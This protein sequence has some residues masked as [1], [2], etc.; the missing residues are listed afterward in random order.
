MAAKSDAVILCRKDWSV[1]RHVAATTA[2][3]M[4][5]PVVLVDEQLENL[6]Y[7]ASLTTLLQAAGVTALLVQG[8]PRGTVQLASKL[9]SAAI[10]VAVVRHAGIGA[11]TSHESLPLQKLL[12]LSAQGDVELAFVDEGGETTYARRLGV[13][14]CTLTLP[15]MP[16]QLRP[17]PVAGLPAHGGAAGA[18]L[19]IGVWN[20]D[21]DTEGVHKHALV[22]L[23]AACMVPQAEVHATVPRVW[24]DGAAGDE[25]RCNGKLVAQGQLHGAQLAEGVAAMHVNLC[26]SW[27]QAVPHAALASLRAGV[28][29]VLSGTSSLFRDAPLLQRL[30]VE[31]RSDDAAAL[32]RRV[33]LVR[34]FLSDSARRDAYD[35][36]VLE[37]LARLDRLARSSWACFVGGL[38]AVGHSGAAPTCLRESNGGGASGG[39][40]GSVCQAQPK[41]A[42]LYDADVAVAAAVSSAW[43]QPGAVRRD[44]AQEDTLGLEEAR[45]WRARAAA[46]AQAD[47]GVG[48]LRG[49]KRPA[50]VVGDL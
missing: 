25:V 7:I 37:T 9:R 14:A 8:A 18:L 38:K 4:G 41:L 17:K 12:Q 10:G 13:A 28:P 46:D 15:F 33:L 3:A 27:G 48:G 2:S 42:G 45:L 31:P 5:Y 11:A 1:M 49:Y 20:D 50:S 44:V 29:V 24:V 35:S 23:S 32:Y 6:P 43:L 40:G 36:A 21:G 30:L 47:N 26:G 34:S 39:S 19:R 16:L 22:Q